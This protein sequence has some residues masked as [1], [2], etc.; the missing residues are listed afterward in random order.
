MLAF[1]ERQVALG[2]VGLR[3]YRHEVPFGCVE[4]DGDRVTGFEE[5]PLVSRLVNAGIYVLSPELVARVPRGEPFALPQLFVDCLSNGETVAGYE[6]ADDW[7][8]VGQHEQLRAARG[9]S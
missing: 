5:K 1:H 8:D 9:E 7:I 3:R 2:T 6:I 4:L